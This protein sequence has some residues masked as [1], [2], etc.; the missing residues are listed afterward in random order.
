MYVLVSI[1]IG[2]TSGLID[3]NSFYEIYSDEKIKFD[4]KEGAITIAASAYNVGLLSASILGSIYS[5]YLIA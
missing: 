1:S 2:L 3:A 5:K 4:E